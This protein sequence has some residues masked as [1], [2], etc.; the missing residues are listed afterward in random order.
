L[1]KSKEEAA[2]DARRAAGAGDTS[3]RFELARQMLEEGDKE[4]ALQFAEPALVRADMQSV[5]F[6]SALR[7]KDAATA[8]RLYTALVARAEADPASDA[9]NV[10]AF[11]SYLFTPFTFFTATSR[12]GMGTGRMRG[13]TVTPPAVTPDRK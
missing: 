9:N 1:A 5:G 12:G 13:D 11:M 7:E 2:E 4:R 3:Q 6:L 10:S 8:D